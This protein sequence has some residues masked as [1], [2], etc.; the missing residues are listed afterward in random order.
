MHAS[1][2]ASQASRYAGSS[3][4]RSASR[5]APLPW[6]ASPCAWPLRQP[7]S[8]AVRSSS[9]AGGTRVSPHAT[10]VPPSA[11]RPSVRL[12]IGVIVCHLVRE[13]TLRCIRYRELD[14]VDHAG[15]HP[16]DRRCSPDRL[17]RH[18]LIL[19]SVAPKW[20]RG[21]AVERLGG[22]GGPP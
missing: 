13:P 16:G 9:N 6:R 19:R 14:Q 7:A 2:P 3:A 11:S 1:Y 22:G 5:V 21:G 18:P 15:A 20:R 8:H 17:S 10:R 4:Y 12:K